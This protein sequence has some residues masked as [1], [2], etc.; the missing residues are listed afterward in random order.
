M[1]GLAGPSSRSSPDRPKT[2]GPIHTPPFPP[3]PQLYKGE[4][5]GAGPSSRPHTKRTP[6]TCLP[7]S[8]SIKHPPPL[9]TFPLPPSAQSQ[10]P[11]CIPPLWF[12]LDHRARKG[13]GRGRKGE[14]QK[15]TKGKKG[16]SH[17]S[18]RRRRIAS[19]PLP[20]TMEKRNECPP[21]PDRY[22]R[23]RGAAPITPLPPPPLNGGSGGGG[24]DDGGRW[25]WTPRHAAPAC[26]PAL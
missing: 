22:I 24:G 20:S 23:R 13:R 11:T 3:L 19:Y 5:K 26:P 17:I 12:V 4:E 2:E 10:Q 8:V 7:A 1:I 16:P 9:F 18:R 15:K 6:V 21:V 14:K 25:A